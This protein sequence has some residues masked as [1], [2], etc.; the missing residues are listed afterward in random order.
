MIM[1]KL[2]ENQSANI[3]RT[4][5]T[6]EYFSCQSKPLS[7]TRSSRQAGSK[8]RVRRGRGS[9]RVSMKWR[10]SWGSIGR[11]GCR[12]LI[13]TTQTS[14]F[15]TSLAKKRSLTPIL[16]QC[17]FR[18]TRVAILM[19]I[20]VVSMVLGCF[21][22]MLIFWK[23]KTKINMRNFWKTRINWLSSDFRLGKFKLKGKLISSCFIHIPW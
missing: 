1:V 23:E 12:L 11:R 20:S 15:T 9:P 8:V 13:L 3:G 5:A 6:R 2:S 18:L 21:R 16:N 10:G 19:K 7:D 17:R 14:T 22:R 4:Q